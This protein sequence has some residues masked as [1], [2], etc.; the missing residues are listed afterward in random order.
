MNYY[1]DYRGGEV[2]LTGK[3]FSDQVHG[4]WKDE[5]NT[6]TVAMMV[7]IS[8]SRGRFCMYVSGKWLIYTNEIH[9]NSIMYVYIYIY[10]NIYTCQ[11]IY[12]YVY[13]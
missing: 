5:K 4:M 13:I 12:V 2:D 1:R 10:T 7:F 9:I 6:K 3:E 8:L 11:Y